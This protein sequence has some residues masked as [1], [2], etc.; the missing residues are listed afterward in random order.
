MK[1]LILLSLAAILCSSVKAQEE[2]F[3]PSYKYRVTLKDKKATTYSVKHPEK[4]LSEKA[5]ERRKRQGIKIDMTDIP[6]CQTYLDQISAKG[7]RVVHTSKWNNTAL[8]QTTDTMRMDEVLALPFVTAVRKVATYSKPDDRDTTDRFSL[9]R[10]ASQDDDEVALEDDDDVAYEQGEEDDE[11]EMSADKIAESVGTSI[12]ESFTEVYG[13]LDKLPKAKQDSIRITKGT[14]VT[15]VVDQFNMQQ[16]QS[17]EEEAEEEVDED[18][19]PL[20]DPALLEDLTIQPDPATEDDV[21]DALAGTMGRSRESVQPKEEIDYGKG[22]GQIKML[23]G[24]ELHK[25]GYKGKGMTIAVIDG[26][27]YNADIIPDLQNVDILG[28]HDFVNPGHDNVFEEETHGM[29]VLSTIAMNQPGK[30]I[31]TAPEASFWLLR[32]EDGYTEQLVEE[33]NWCAAIEF[34]DSIGVDVVNTSLGYTKFDNPADNVKYWELD[35]HTHMA[36]NSASMAASKGMVLCQSAGNEAF[37]STWKL[38]GVPAD[39]D[40][41]LSVGA[42][43]PDGINT[44]FSSIGNSADGRIKPDVC[45]QG[46]DCAVM[47]K[48]GE[49]TTADGTSFSSPITCGMVACFWQAHPNLT[50]KQVIE[51]VRMRGSNVEHPDNVFGYGIPD[52]AK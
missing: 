43:R 20:I 46:E 33:D 45:A 6:V 48:N 25:K 42:L 32:S 28:V 17:G 37:Y 3:V 30:M 13:D 41:I 11:D 23:N 34:A 1:K 14:L 7:V 24:I 39:A 9:I 5:I 50:A 21:L 49:L 10:G 52:Y 31:G 36:S 8:V 15:L 18:D 47:N 27:F 4:F 29:M 12:D 19:K 26:G 38:I 51:A 22:Y 2:A 35:G 40:N 16:N 44:Y